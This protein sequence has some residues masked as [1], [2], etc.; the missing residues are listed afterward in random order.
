MTA[1]V[2]VSGDGAVG[3]VVGA[4]RLR[5]GGFCVGVVSDQ[6]IGRFPRL[7]SSAPLAAALLRLCCCWSRA[8][9][10]E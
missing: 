5:F 10:T 7:L 1:M 4:N 2:V 6:L 9:A 3:V 8:I